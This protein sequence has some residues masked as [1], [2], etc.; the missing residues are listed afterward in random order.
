M[1]IDGTSVNGTRDVW[2]KDDDR[3]L[4]SEAQVIGRAIV[5]IDGDRYVVHAVL[6]AS[7]RSRDLGAR[8]AAFFHP[9]TGRFVALPMEPT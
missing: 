9:E 7:G 4:L 2:H 5:H 3:S 1:M 6:V 8:Y